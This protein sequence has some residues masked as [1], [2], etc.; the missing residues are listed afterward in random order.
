MKRQIAYY[1][2]E[3]YPTIWNHKF[4]SLLGQCLQQP[5]ICQY[6]QKPILLL[7][8]NLR[9]HPYS[10]C[11]LKYFLHLMKRSSYFNFKSFL[12]IIHIYIKYMLIIYNTSIYIYIMYNTSAWF[13]I[14]IIINNRNWRFCNFINT[15]L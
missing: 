11:P 13:L 3:L 2:D 10:L 15:S 12:I 8:D 6:N 5:L 14:T 7:S 1:Q 9:K 4:N